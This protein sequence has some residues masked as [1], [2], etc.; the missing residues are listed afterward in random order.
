MLGSGSTE[1]KISSRLLVGTS[2]RIMFCDDTDVKHSVFG[3]KRWNEE[4]VIRVPVTCGLFSSLGRK[5]IYFSNKFH[6][7]KSWHL[8]CVKFHCLHTEA[9]ERTLLYL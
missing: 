6:I 2:W 1:W 7:T 4:K 5:L 8:I 9:E 3:T